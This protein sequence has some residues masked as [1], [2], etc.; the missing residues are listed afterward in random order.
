M[1]IFSLK[2]SCLESRNFQ[3]EG[4][5]GIRN[6]YDFKLAVSDFRMRH[7]FRGESVLFFCGRY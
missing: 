1:N 5:P 4:H 6:I 3:G 2:Y 7:I